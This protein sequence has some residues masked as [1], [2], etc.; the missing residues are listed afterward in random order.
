MPNEKAKGAINTRRASLKASS[1][2]T[3]PSGE[4]A[5]VVGPVCEFDSQKMPKN[6]FPRI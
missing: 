6:N 2:T 3:Q 4:A 5:V 1:T